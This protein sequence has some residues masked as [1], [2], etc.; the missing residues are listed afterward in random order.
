MRMSS[1]SCLP[2]LS[3]LIILFSI[4]A[5]LVNFFIYQ[6][7][8]NNFFPEHMLLLINII[9]LVNIGLFLMYGKK[10]R[11]YY[12]GIEF[13]YFFTVM[14]IIALATNAVQL[15]P[16]STIDRE[17][18]TFE[19]YFHIDI[20]AILSWTDK[21]PGLRNVLVFI[22]DTLPYQMSL[23]PLAVIASGRFAL[24]KEYY[25][26]LLITT[27]TGFTFYYF[28]PTTAPA[29]IVNSPFFSPEQIATGLKFNQIHHHQ[30]P[31]TNE[32][33]LIA[34]PSFHTIWALLCVYLLK[35][36]TIPWLLLLI[37]NILLIASCVLLGW[38][39]VSDVLG[40]FIVTAFSFYCLTFYKIH[41]PSQQN[42]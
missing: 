15:T 13:F 6:F 36:W 7:P 23:L 38:H 4:I 20:P 14:S 18:L 26:L 9:I 25:F 28:F 37:V 27:L 5:L 24:M 12:S 29:S 40:A 1:L 16:F 10:S 2:A 31:T 21:H 19:H 30:L 39:Y 22:Y 41:C 3:G 35:E 17:I 33:G 32:G 8:G 42:I 34:L 11:A